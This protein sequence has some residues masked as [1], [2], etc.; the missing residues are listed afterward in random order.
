MAILLIFLLLFNILIIDDSRAYFQAPD[1]KSNDDVKQC[2][3]EVIGDFLGK[4][5]EREKLS[6][7]YEH[8]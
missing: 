2:F 1:D 5:R 8:T 4:F 3:C 7:K 6:P